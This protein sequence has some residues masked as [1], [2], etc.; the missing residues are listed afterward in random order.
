MPGDES[1][2][3]LWMGARCVAAGKASYRL[4][5]YNIP[6]IKTAAAAPAHSGDAGTLPADDGEEDD[7]EHDGEDAEGA[8]TEAAE[9]GEE[10]VVEGEEAPM[11]AVV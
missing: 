5:Y 2:V 9:G 3:W 8:R 7:S 4:K 11:P 6:D 10:A 1:R